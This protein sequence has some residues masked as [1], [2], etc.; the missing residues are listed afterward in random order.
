MRT[1]IPG[2]D[3][4]SL[5]LNSHV[6]TDRS[7]GGFIREARAQ[8]WWDSTLVIIVGDHGHRLPVLDSLQSDRK[9]ELYTIPMLW[10][11]G[12]LAV[13]DTVISGLGVQTDIPRTLLAQ[14]G[15]DQSAY[16]WSRNLL[17]RDVRPWAWFTF[18]DGFGWVN[19]AGGSLAWDNV[20]KRMIARQGAAGASDLRDGQAL[21]QVLIDDYIR[22]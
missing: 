2:R 14:L 1:V 15:L 11:G 13:R 17:A 6:Y 12:A 5:F 9:W 7:I 16:A 4:Q 20:G 22:R 10:L 8:P 18:T 3:Q 21:L 19:Q